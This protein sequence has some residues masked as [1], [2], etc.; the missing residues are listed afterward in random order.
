M[1]SEFKKKYHAGKDEEEQPIMK[2]F[3]LH[4]IQ[5]GLKDL[6]GDFVVH[7]APYPKDFAV[8]VKQLSKN[9]N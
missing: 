4:A 7:E 3:A 2:R 9:K 6:A 8:A 1:L 5:L